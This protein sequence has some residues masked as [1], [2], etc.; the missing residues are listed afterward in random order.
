[1][2]LAFGEEDEAL[3]VDALRDGGYSW[4]SLVAE[5]QGHVVGHILFSELPIV[6]PAGIV[7]G[8][9]LAPMA[10]IPSHQGRGI[11]SMLVREGLGAGRSAGHRVVVVVGPPGFSPRFGFS[12]ALAARLRSPYSGPACM[13]LELVP[14]ALEG[15]EGDVRYPPPFTNF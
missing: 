12:T 11:G 14:G 6:T 9:S 5:D 1:N 7:A 8:L 4:V 10:V 2:R 13:A 15:V 3:L